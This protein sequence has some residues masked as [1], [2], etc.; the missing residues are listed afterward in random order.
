M[1][2]RVLGRSGITVSAMG[3]G[4]WALSGPLWAGEQ[5]I[6]W[7][8]VDDDESIR[9]IRRAY[10]LGVT[11]FDVA[12]SYGAGHGERVL[13]RA[14]AANRDEVVIATKWGNTFDEGAR[15][16]GPAD[17]SPEYLRRAVRDSLRR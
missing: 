6:G 16:M 15:Q 1:T 17:G 3:M 10:A 11:F 5:P 4:C 2:P 14:L 7:G 8:N 13:G 9:A 12:D